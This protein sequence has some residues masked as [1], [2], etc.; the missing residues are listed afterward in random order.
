VAP[1][2]CALTLCRVPCCLPANIVKRYR[3]GS[4]VRLP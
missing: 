2:R 3:H 1:H 4:L